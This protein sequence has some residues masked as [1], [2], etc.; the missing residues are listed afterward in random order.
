M[1]EKDPKKTEKP[2]EG[3]PELKVPTN[4]D[5][6]HLR[7][8]LIRTLLLRERKLDLD[9]PPKRINDMEAFLKYGYGTDELYD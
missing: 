9:S 5:I 4:E 2:I 7:E 6:L 1:I 3:L 8:Q